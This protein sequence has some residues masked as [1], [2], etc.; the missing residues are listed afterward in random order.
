MPYTFSGCGTRYY[1]QRERGEDGSYVTTEWV[2]LVYVPI[3]PFR[4]YRVVP[5][6]KG[7]NYVVHSSQNYQAR[8]VPLCWEQVRNVYFVVSP[9]VLLLVYFNW[10]DIRSWVKADLLKSSVSRA[11]TPNAVSAATYATPS[12]ESAFARLP[13]ARVVVEQT[14]AAPHGFV[15]WVFGHILDDKSTPIK[16]TLSCT[17]PAP[18]R[19]A[20]LKSGE[21]YRIKFLSDRDGAA[22]PRESYVLGSVMASG[23]AGKDLVFYIVDEAAVHSVAA[24]EREERA[25]AKKDPK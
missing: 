20:E 12:T 21:I 2:T 23:A 6:G 16:L 24:R 14:V 18:S 19:C 10:G 7:T 9:I 5:V 1:G 13:A 4:S 22:Y 11:V 25:A 15:T 17:L 3:L 8:R